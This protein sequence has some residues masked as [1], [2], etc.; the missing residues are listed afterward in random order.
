MKK[1]LNISI[2]NLF[3]VH[4]PVGEYL[5]VRE[6]PEYANLCNFPNFSGDCISDNFPTP[7]HITG[8]HR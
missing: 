6:D 4:F 7:H 5:L 3:Q 2:W 8:I 1:L